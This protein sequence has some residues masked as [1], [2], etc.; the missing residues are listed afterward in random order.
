MSENPSPPYHA[1]PA[2]GEVPNPPACVV[3]GSP[4]RHRWGGVLPTGGCIAYLRAEIGTLQGEVLALRLQLAA[5]PDPCITTYQQ[6]ALATGIPVERLVRLRVFAPEAERCE[7]LAYDAQLHCIL[8][9]GHT[10]AHVP[11][12]QAAAAVADAA[13]WGQQSQGEEA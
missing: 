4:E 10:G 11:Q 5:R 7:A 13:T 6:L 2:Q 3:C 9:A 12:T 8:A 1:S